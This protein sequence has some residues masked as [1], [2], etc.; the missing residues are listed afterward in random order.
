M[1]IYDLRSVAT[2]L[3]FQRSGYKY[4]YVLL[5]ILGLGCI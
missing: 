5:T 2:H 4:D 1:Y 3:F